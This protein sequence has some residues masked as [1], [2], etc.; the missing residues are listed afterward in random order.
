MGPTTPSGEPDAPGYDELLEQVL[1]TAPH[2]AAAL[3]RAHRNR[4][5]ELDRYL[6]ADALRTHFAG[7]YVA[8][9]DEI[10]SV[11][12]AIIDA[13]QRSVVLK[14]IRFLIMRIRADFESA[15]DAALSGFNGVVLDTMRDVM[16]VEYLLE[17]FLRDAQHIREWFNA[18]RATLLGKFSPAALR[19]RQAA[20]ADIA[21]EKLPDAFEY[22]LHSEGLH[23]LPSFMLNDLAGKGFT[24]APFPRAVEFAFAE[25]FE[26]GRRV[27]LAAYDLGA[28]VEGTRW[29]APDV[30][31]GMPEAAK[32]WER[33]KVV[34]ALIARCERGSEASDS[35]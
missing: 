32:A 30:R 7:T 10:F 17:D 2:V 6:N 24:A 15:I 26:H 9:L 3:T 33:T 12:D 5:R 13:Y 25:M 34:M 27:I 23:V 14:D 21:P 20:A 1:Q 35:T 4:T 28:R 11:L 22:R 18:D 16:E 19:R 8:G 31:I 29:A